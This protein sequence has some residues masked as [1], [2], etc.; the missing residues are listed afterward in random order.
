[1]HEWLPRYG[2]TV[3]LPKPFIFDLHSKLDPSLRRSTIFYDNA[4]SIFSWAAT[5]RIRPAHST[6]PVRPGFCFLFD[7]FNNLVFAAG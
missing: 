6:S 4:A 3:A 2:R 5:Q 1:M 7:P